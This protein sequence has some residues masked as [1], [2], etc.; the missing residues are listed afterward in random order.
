M[1][2]GSRE[3]SLKIEEIK[4]IKLF[5]FLF[6]IVFVGFDIIYYY[7]YP[8]FFYVERGLPSEGL[9]FYMHIIFIL[10]V[11]VTIYLIKNGDPYL[12]KY[13]Y[14]FSY[15]IID[16]I[17]NILIYSG[18]DKV[19]SSGNIVEIF[20]LLFAPIFVNKCYFWVVSISM[21]LKYVFF[22]LLFQ[23]MNVV[24][25][26]VLIVFFSLF[27][28]ILLSRFISYVNGMVSIY[29]ESKQKEKLAVFG[30]MAASIAHEIKNPLSALRGFTQLQQEK[31]GSKENYY[32]IMLN[33]IDRINLIVSDLL[34]IGKPNI[35][36]KKRTSIKGII[37]YVVS[38]IEHQASRMSIEIQM[39]IEDN[40]PGFYCDENQIKQVFIN[41]LKNSVESMQNGG[42]ILVTTRFR[43]DKFFITV[44][45]EGE[46]I[47]QDMI[48]RLG[49]PFF[50]TKRNG[51]GLG[52]MVTKK[53]IEE[54]GGKFVIKQTSKEGTIIE[55]VLPNSNN[56]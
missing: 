14:L 49:E 56:S 52:I 2:E 1:G 42:R 20:L 25:P 10:L 53:I 5:I 41:L 40:L 34:L 45:D 19:Y 47:P 30:Q 51:T 13:I 9:G 26:I 39:D 31:D 12:I 54:H 17:N 36:T 16:L 6:Y 38:I 8:S 3:E 18:T 15:L 37:D 48:D 23:S 28:Y 55:V 33:E 44:K 46:G 35:T 27:G 29:E 50:T 4:A 11:P 22:G 7:I 32:P 21:T 43:D 24:V